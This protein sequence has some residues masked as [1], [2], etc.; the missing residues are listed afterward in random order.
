M[1]KLTLL[2]G[3][4]ASGKSTKAAEIVKDG[5]VRING[6]LMREMLHFNKF[7]G[8]NEG[9][10]QNMS[11]ILAE[12]LLDCGKSVVIDNT[13]LNPNTVESWRELVR[14]TDHSFEIVDIDTSVEECIR[15]DTARAEKGERSVGADVIRKMALQYKG[16]MD[17]QKVIVSDMDGT[18]S[19]CSHRQGWVEKTPKD[20]DTF[21]SLCKF[22]SLRKEVYDQVVSYNLPIVIVSARPEKCRKDTECWL[23]KFNINYVALIM[24]EDHDSRPDT[25]VKRDIYNKYLKNLSIV[26]IFDDRPSII[27]LWSELGLDVVDVGKGIPF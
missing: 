3:L 19:D 7:T 17:G 8:K 14:N 25:E 6:D 22:D 12:D 13:N 9:I 27:S 26:K 20:W 4:P 24:R 18:L 15:R 21:F 11:K 5:M 16:Y 2:R 23:N 1:S 10:T